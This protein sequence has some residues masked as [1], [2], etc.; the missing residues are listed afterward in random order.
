LSKGIENESGAPSSLLEPENIEYLE[1]PTEEGSKAE[2]DTERADKKQM[3]GKESANSSMILNPIV[4]K[5]EP[6]HLQTP[7]NQDKPEIETKRGQVLDK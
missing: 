2:M 4:E 7:Q 1:Q 5:P 3:I 6:K